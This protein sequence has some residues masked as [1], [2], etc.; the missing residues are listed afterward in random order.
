MSRGPGVMQRSLLGLAEILLETASAECLHASRSVYVTTPTATH[1]VC[2]CRVVSRVEL[3]DALRLERLQRGEALNFAAYN[4]SAR[5]ALR[6]L[7]QVGALCPVWPVGAAGR[8]IEAF[9]LPYYLPENHHPDIVSV[10]IKVMKTSHIKEHLGYTRGSTGRQYLLL[11]I[12]RD[13]PKIL[14]RFVAGEFHSAH[15]AAKEAGLVGAKTR[16]QAAREPERKEP[17]P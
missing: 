7:I 15:A 5:R 6:H 17:A 3:M 2:S 4:G 16:A 13:H 11:R 12:A 14:V 9:T 8:R 10:P 1:G